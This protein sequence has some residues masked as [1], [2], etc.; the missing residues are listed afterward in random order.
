MNCRNFLSQFGTGFFGTQK[1]RIFT[2]S[3]GISTERVG[4]KNFRNICEENEKPSETCIHLPFIILKQ[5]KQGGWMKTF[6]F[7]ENFKYF[8]TAFKWVQQNIPICN[9]NM[10]VHIFYQN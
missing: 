7:E 2:A 10:Y 9:V 5:R 4:W 3:L 1:N 8:S 6:C